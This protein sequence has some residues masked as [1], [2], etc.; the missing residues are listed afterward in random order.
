MDNDF[1]FMMYVCEE[2]KKEDFI[3]ALAQSA[4]P[5]NLIIQ[6]AI[7]ERIG[8]DLNTLSQGDIEYIESEVSKRWSGYF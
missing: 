4:D 1:V 6:H 2:Q 5:N 8:L 3:D 7:A